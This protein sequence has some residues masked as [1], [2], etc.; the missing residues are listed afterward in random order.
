VQDPSEAAHPTMPAAALRLAEP[1]FVLP[2]AVLR[3][4]LHTVVR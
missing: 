3:R 4:L 1:D 2:V